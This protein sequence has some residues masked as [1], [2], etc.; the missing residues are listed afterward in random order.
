[1]FPT[2]LFSLSV[3]LSLQY[4]LHGRPPWIFFSLLSCS[5]T[6]FPIDCVACLPLTAGSYFLLSFNQRPLHESNGLLMVAVLMLRMATRMCDVEP[7]NKES[8]PTEKADV[9]A[10]QHLKTPFVCAGFSVDPVPQAEIAT[11]TA[12]A[13]DPYSAVPRDQPIGGMAMSMPPQSQLAQT[14]LTEY[15]PLGAALVGNRCVVSQTVTPVSSFLP[16]G[17]S[18]TVNGIT[19]SNVPQSSSPYTQAMLAN[20]SASYAGASAIPPQSGGGQVF[21]EGRLP[22]GYHMVQT[23][24]QGQGQLAGF[25]GLHGLTASAVLLSG[26]GGE[27]SASQ[28]QA[29]LAR[30][31]SSLQGRVAA[32]ASPSPSPQVGSGTLHPQQGP[33]GAGPARPQSKGGTLHPQ[34]G[35]GS[36][37]ALPAPSSSLASVHP[38]QDPSVV[39][40]HPHPG[41]STTGL[42]GQ[43]QAQP[44]LAAQLASGSHSTWV[45]AAALQQ[46]A[47][48]AASYHINGF[49]AT[50]QLP[51]SKA[52]VTANAIALQQPKFSS[53]PGHMN[54]MSPATRVT[55]NTTASLSTITKRDLHLGSS[56]SSTIMVS[57]A[58]SPPVSG[59]KQAPRIAALTQHS[60]TGGRSGSPGLPGY[61]PVHSP[62]PTPSPQGL[63]QILPPFSPALPAYQGSGA[64]S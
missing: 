52:A 33:G 7:G 1:M 49:P 64:G 36:S 50:A 44:A 46:Q 8:T 63:N 31:V 60:R 27:L 22:Q 5:H 39:S 54:N 53:V 37:S 56:H 43:L 3:H 16:A 6:C 13:L 42:A 21:S 45:H 12:P 62:S 29:L 20:L 57:Q 41:P 10:L 23:A 40:V 38:Q 51:Y 58:P 25:S 47:G 48:G 24:G 34:P 18:T 19:V 15:G 28:Q 32:T 2:H 30:G 11:S 17:V 14:P 55:G 59:L 35:P 9:P 4:T 26:A 61:G